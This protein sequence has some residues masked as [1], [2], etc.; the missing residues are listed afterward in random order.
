MMLMVAQQL[1]S[2]LVMYIFHLIWSEVERM[3]SSSLPYGLMLTNFLIEA[4]VQIQ[5]DEPRLWQSELINEKTAQQSLIHAR[6][7]HVRRA[8]PRNPAPKVRESVDAGKT[9]V[10][11]SPT[12]SPWLDELQQSVTEAVRLALTPIEARLT[13]LA[14]IVKRTVRAHDLQVVITRIDSV[15]TAIA[16]M[17]E[18][19]TTTLETII[20]RPDPATWELILFMFIYLFFI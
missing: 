12:Q 1:P 11:G 2:D 18:D 13:Q 6:P 19:I 5:P 14:H 15:S 17:E 9:S 16:E 4:G 10:A 3:S 8:Q 20:Q 7:R